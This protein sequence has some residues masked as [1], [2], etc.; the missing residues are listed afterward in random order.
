[1]VHC[2]PFHVSTRVCGIDPG[3]DEPTATQ[4]FE[5]VHETPLSQLL[6]LGDVLAL[7]WMDH[8]E[9]SQT[10]AMDWT[11]PNVES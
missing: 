3:E 2:A 11:K 1:M 5:E 9:P 7:C 8:R 10:T 4:L 6:T